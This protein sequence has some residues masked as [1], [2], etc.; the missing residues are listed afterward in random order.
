MYFAD[1]GNG[2]AVAGAGAAEV[3][4]ASGVSVASFVPLEHAV[5]VPSARIATTPSS[6][7]RMCFFM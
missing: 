1:C 4:D 3:P 5:R 2:D 7:M 6:R